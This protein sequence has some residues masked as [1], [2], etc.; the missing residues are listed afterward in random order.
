MFSVAL[1]LSGALLFSC[2]NDISVVNS[3]QPNDDAPVQSSYQVESFITDS[4]KVRIILRAPVIDSYQQPEEYT[5]MP[6][7]VFL[8]FIDSTGKASSSLRADY[9]INKTKEKKVIAKYNVIAVNSEGD[10]LFTE[11][12]IWDQKKRQIYTNQ[13]VKVVSTD[14]TIFGDGLTA[15][16]NFDNWQIL[17]PTGEFE[18]ETP[19]ME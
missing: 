11:K 8:M 2:E 17:H 12:L 10:S 18:A 16:E 19:D 3:L 5:E 14:R 7:G 6:K 9:A 1:V 15:D 4:G 13:P